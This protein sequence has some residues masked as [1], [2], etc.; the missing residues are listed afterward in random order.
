M[1]RTRHPVETILAPLL[2]PAAEKAQMLAQELAA[3]P[4]AIQSGLRPTIRQL[5]QLFGRSA[6]EAAAHRLM[7]RIKRE[8]DLSEPLL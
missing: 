8:R 7:Q 5:E 4:V 2:D 1:S 6:V 3:P